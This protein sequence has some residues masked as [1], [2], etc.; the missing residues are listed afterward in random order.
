MSQQPERSRQ[1][2]RIHRGREADI[3]FDRIMAEA[4]E[5]LRSRRDASGPSEG[6]DGK[7]TP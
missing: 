6:L 1:E 7:A 5:A 3:A 4:L 2:R